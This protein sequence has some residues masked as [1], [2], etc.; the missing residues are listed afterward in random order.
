MKILLTGRTGQVGY[1]LE[2][3]L[4]GLGSIVALDRAQLDLSDPARIREVLRAIRPA[5]IVNAA[6]Y[7]AV[8]QAESEFDLA[9]RINAE[10][11]AVLAE[12]ARALGAAMIHYSTEHVFDGTKATPYVEDDAPCPVNA[13]GRSKLAGEQAVQTAGIPYLI[14][15]T[16]WVYGLR[17]R[18]FLTTVLRLA[19]ESDELRM[20]DD[21][22]GA[23]TWCRTIAD[24]TAHVIAAG[25]QSAND[26]AT[27][28]IASR[29]MCE[30]WPLRS[31]IYHLAAQGRTTRYQFA[32]TILGHPSVAKKS[33]VTAIGARELSLPARR[34]TNSM[35]S[36]ER[37][38]QAFCDL[39]DWKGAL[40]LCQNR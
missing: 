35:L 7:T 33:T 31:G 23:P 38:K 16:S 2:R 19:Q 12:E 29:I 10:A 8:D 3:S 34:P 17:R 28:D 1:E 9:W 15:R 25:C 32:K 6:A 40:E 13:Y 24:I 30:A 11:P 37:L 20:V 26:N 39:P 14:F 22:Y 36:C 5:L 4:Q 21:Q 27:A 18:N